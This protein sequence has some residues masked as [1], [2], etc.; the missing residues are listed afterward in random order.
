VL[1]VLILV[2][3]DALM[4]LSSFFL[5]LLAVLLFLVGI[6][7]ELSLSGASV[8][9][10]VEAAVFGTQTTT[11]G[12]NLACP[13][14]LSSSESGMVSTLIANSLDQQ[15]SPLVITEIS[16]GGVPQSLSRTLLLPP[17]QDQTL[18][19][20]V[21]DS[22][23]IFGRLILVNVV[24][25]RYAD[26]DPH[27]GFCGILVFDLFNLTGYE[28]LVLILIGG[29]L[30]ILVGG[31]LWSRLHAPLNELAEQTLKACGALAGVTTFAVLTALPRWWGLTLFLDAFALIMLVV[32]F[33]DFLLF[34]GS[35]GK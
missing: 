3:F 17:H 2:I 18:Q 12:L 10:E 5:S 22:D 4:K 33:T 31:L 25:S 28:S 30:L 21:D 8:W 15:V 14:M 6:A 11:G 19:W 20:S 1:S 26:L 9:A 32:L 16:R 7:L 29:F 35:G 23:L 34:P 24:Q 13:L 27:R